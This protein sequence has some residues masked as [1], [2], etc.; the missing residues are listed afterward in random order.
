MKIPSWQNKLGKT[1]RTPLNCG[2]VTSTMYTFGIVNVIPSPIPVRNLPTVGQF[3]TRVEFTYLIPY[4]IFKAAPVSASAVFYEVF[5]Y[6]LK[7]IVVCCRLIKS[8][9]YFFSLFRHSDIMS[10]FSGCF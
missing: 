7:T 10:K 6:L 1:P 5:F 9:V 8:F 3:F 2:S 4:L